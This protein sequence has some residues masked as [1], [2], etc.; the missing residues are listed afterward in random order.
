M[1]CSQRLWDAGDGHYSVYRVLL[2]INNVFQLVT[3]IDLLYGLLY[4]DQTIRNAM[5]QTLNLAIRKAA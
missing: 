4:L 2:H 5:K 1:T 3:A